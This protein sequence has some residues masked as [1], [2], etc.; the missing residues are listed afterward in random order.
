[1]EEP[2]KKGTT[3]DQASIWAEY[4]FAFPYHDMGV[5]Q[6]LDNLG[7][8][9]DVHRLISDRKA[10][11]I[12]YK[13]RPGVDNSMIHS[14]MPISGEADHDMAYVHS[15][16]SRPWGSR[17]RSAPAPSSRPIQDW[18]KGSYRADGLASKLS[19]YVAGA[20]LQWTLSLW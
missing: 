14:P 8:K 2:K 11:R 17:Y 9:Y 15:Q 1:M 20:G 4:P 18:G 6:V 3:Q 10:Q 13:I 5:S 19:K 7:C 16:Y 12:S